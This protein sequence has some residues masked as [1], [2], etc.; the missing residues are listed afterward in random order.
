MSELVSIIIANYNYGRYLSEAIESALNQTY[1][2]VEVIFIDDGSSDDSVEVACRYD[3]TVLGQQNQGVSAARNAAAVF[4]RGEYLLFLDSDDRLKLD[5]VDKL[6]ALIKNG[7]PDVG[8]AYGQLQYFDQKDW[9]FESRPFDP[10]A[11]AKNNYIQTSALIRKDVFNEVG[12]F[13]RG[14]A[15]REDWE[16]FIRIWHVG[17]RGAYLNEPHIYYRKHRPKVEVRRRSSKT[18]KNLSMAKLIY[19][20]PK[21]FILR[22]LRN[23][24]KWV[25]YI[26]RYKVRDLVGH[27]GAL[28]TPKIIQEST[29]R[30]A[31]KA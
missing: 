25:Y 18:K 28:Q 15:L 19:K 24:I 23:P 11:L 14:F 12:G 30:R 1:R 4:A 16:L 6:L 10:K 27:Y 26:L 20:F 8:Y 31:A 17:F 21:F 7:T 9:I 29:T 2:N 3:V 22:F 5:A 13:D